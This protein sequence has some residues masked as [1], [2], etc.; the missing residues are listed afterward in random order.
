MSLLNVNGTLHHVG[1]PDAA[2]PQISAQ[3]FT[4]NGCT[5]GASHIGN[6]GEM[7]AML[8]LVAEKEIKPR[9]E[10]LQVG[11]QGCKEAVSRVD[12]NEVRY[13]FTLTGYD[14]AFGT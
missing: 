9:V 2:L 5:M 14:K 13:R 11:E 12:K 1:L 7:I 4:A 10:I 6:R 8:K 3:D